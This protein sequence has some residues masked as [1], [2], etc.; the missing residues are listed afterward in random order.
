MKRKIRIDDSDFPEPE[1]GKVRKVIFLDI[2]GVLNRDDGG[3]K[4]E[5]CLAKRLAHIVEE[6]GAEIVLSSSWR[7][8]YVSHVNPDYNYQ[9]KDVA[10]LIS[11]LE[12]YQLSIMDVTP[13]L[14]SG[15]YARPL[16]IRAWLLEQG[17]LERFVILDDET[18][19]VWNWLGDY[20]VCT[21]HMGDNGKCVYGMTDE[22]AEKAIAILNRPQAEKL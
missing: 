5:E 13:D 7:G 11:M 22:D 2:D 1:E 12:K 17:N 6:T 16:E 19:W 21:T 9:N 10:L 18:F 3:P 20:L 15:A 4:I 14:T 8:A